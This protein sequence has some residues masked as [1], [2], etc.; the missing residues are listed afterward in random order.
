[1]GAYGA[2]MIPTRSEEARIA[3][4]VNSMW[5]FL[6]YSERTPAVMKPHGGSGETERGDHDGPSGCGG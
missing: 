3:E 2:G 5:M 6:F 4:P 1:M